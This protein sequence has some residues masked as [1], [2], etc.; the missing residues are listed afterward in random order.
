LKEETTTLLS[1]KQESF[2][3]YT[4]EEIPTYLQDNVYIRV[5]IVLSTL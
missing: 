3:L 2:K 5:N 1:P 4:F